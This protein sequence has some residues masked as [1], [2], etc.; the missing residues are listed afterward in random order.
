MKD[1]QV[2]MASLGHNELM[3][4]IM[5]EM[6]D[7]CK[8]Y[9]EWLPISLTTCNSIRPRCIFRNTTLLFIAYYDMYI[10]VFICIE[11]GINTR[12]QRFHSATTHD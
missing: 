9:C 2:H 12:Q 7:R 3:I 11:Y 4:I 6:L 1:D 10:H 8:E 5:Q